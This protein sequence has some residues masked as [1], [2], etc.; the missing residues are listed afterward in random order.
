MLHYYL[1]SDMCESKT[2]LAHHKGHCPESLVRLV[3]LN[4]HGGHF[5][6]EN[7]SIL[8]LIWQNLLRKSVQKT[9]CY[10]KCHYRTCSLDGKKV[11][12][13]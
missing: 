7:I 1:P 10:T 11:S 2:N 3:V 6:G 8:S 4:E 9:I 5:K 12:S 13:F